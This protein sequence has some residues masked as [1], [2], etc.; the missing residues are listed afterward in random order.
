MNSLLGPAD[1][2]VVGAQDACYEP[3]IRQSLEAQKKHLEE[4][5]DKVNKGLAVLDADPNFAL[6]IELLTKALRA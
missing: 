1:K 2:C 5:L 6:N 3:T 4:R